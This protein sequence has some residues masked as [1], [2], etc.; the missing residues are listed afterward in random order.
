MTYGGANSANLDKKTKYS[1]YLKQNIKP[2]SFASKIQALSCNEVRVHSPRSCVKVD[3]LLFNRASNK[4]NRAELYNVDQVHSLRFLVNL[5]SNS[6][7]I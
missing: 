2:S 5:S 3:C 1:N 6:M 7:R 4:S